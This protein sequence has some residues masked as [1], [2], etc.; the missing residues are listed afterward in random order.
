LPSSLPDTGATITGA[1]ALPVAFYREFGGGEPDEFA[2]QLLADLGKTLDET[3]D[4]SKAVQRPTGIY[5]FGTLA[6]VR[7]GLG[8]TICR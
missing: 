6:R 8:E 4:A 5:A 3:I 1:K 2:E 7:V